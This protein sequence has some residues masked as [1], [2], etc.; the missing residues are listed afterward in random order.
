[1]I[2]ELFLV[3]A[4]LCITIFTC[5]CSCMCCF[6]CFSTVKLGNLLSDSFRVMWR[7]LQITI[8]MLLTVYM[9]FTVAALFQTREPNTPKNVLFT[10]VSK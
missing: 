10:P 9:V 5:I 2:F 1:M 6:H 3:T 4:A 7:I 8:V